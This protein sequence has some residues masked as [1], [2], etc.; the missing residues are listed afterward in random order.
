MINL[1]KQIF[2]WWSRQTIGTSIYTLFTGK[3]I[4]EDK[5]K[6]KYYTNRKGKRWVIYNSEVEASKIPPSWHR[7]IHFITNKIPEKNEPIYSWQ[8]NHVENL[9]GTNEA[10]KPE[11]SLSLKSKKSMKRYETWNS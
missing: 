5:F 1:F 11:G 2:I 4:G 10:H 9:T 6:N 3:L 8:K 7:W